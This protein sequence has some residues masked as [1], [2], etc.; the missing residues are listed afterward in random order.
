MDWRTWSCSTSA[1]GAGSGSRRRSER[2]LRGR[3]WRPRWRTSRA[4]PRKQR[5]GREEQH[6][7]RHF[8]LVSIRPLHPANYNYKSKPFAYTLLYIHIRLYSGSGNKKATKKRQKKRKRSAESR[9]EKSRRWRPPRRDRS[10]SFSR[11]FSSWLMARCRNSLNH[12]V[13]FFSVVSFFA[14]C[15]GGFRLLRHFSADDSDRGASI[16]GEH[17]SDRYTTPRR[18]KDSKRQY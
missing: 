4:S 1:S 18:Q 11:F 12:V 2:R 16:H 3:A 5:N 15:S 7:T 9:R 14:L 6:R 17:G 10:F 13:F 8:K